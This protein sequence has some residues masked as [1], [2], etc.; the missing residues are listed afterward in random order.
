MTIR[1]QSSAKKPQKKKSKVVPAEDWERFDN[2][3]ILDGDGD[4]EDECQ[5]F[6]PI[7]LSGEANFESSKFD[8]KPTIKQQQQR[9]R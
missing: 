1:Q 6:D 2:E 9:F 8:E 4:E 7:L 3:D 5:N